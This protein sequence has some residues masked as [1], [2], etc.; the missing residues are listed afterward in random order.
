MIESV[1]RNKQAVQDLFENN[2]C[3]LSPVLKQLLWDPDFWKHIM[4]IIIILK[5]I[6]DIR[7]S[8]ENHGYKLHH[9]IQGWKQIR[10]HLNFWNIDT[11]QETEIQ[12]LDERLFIPW[13]RK[14]VMDI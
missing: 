11:D 12:V 4:L 2:R 3:E 14:Q 5:S 13:Y 7:Y 9:L 8:S 6:H 10:I 1:S